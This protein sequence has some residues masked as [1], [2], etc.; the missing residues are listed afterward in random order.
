MKDFRDLKKYTEIEAQNDKKDTFFAHKNT[1]SANRISL[2]TVHHKKLWEKLYPI[3]AIG[4][5]SPLKKSN[6]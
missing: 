2:N 4:V 5:V 6:T 3:N 1:H